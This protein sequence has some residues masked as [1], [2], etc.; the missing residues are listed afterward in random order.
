MNRI[1]NSYD[2]ATWDRMT[3]IKSRILR[4]WDTAVPGVRICCVKFAQR[5]V[6]VQT[7]GPDADPR[8]R[9]FSSSPKYDTYFPQKRGEPPEISLSMVPS[10]HPLIP[11]KNLEAEA[12]GLL[13]RMLAV[14]HENSR[15][16]YPPPP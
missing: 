6:L 15:S 11:P 9:M 5:V 2:N 3:A 10:N 1:N 16:V 8:V 7:K 13:D 12:S 14:F 4:M